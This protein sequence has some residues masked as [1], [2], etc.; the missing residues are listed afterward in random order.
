[1]VDVNLKVPALEKLLDYAASGIGAVAR[2]MLAPWKARR[3]AEAR[4][5]GV[6]AEVESLKLIAK[7]HADA[8]SF[9]VV[10]GEAERGV[11]DLGPDGVAQRIEF[12]EER[13]QANIVSVVQ[14]AATELGDKEVP[15]HEPDHDWIARFLDG[16]QDVSAE[17]MRKIWA[18]FLAG[19]VEAP[20]RTSLRTLSVLKNM[21]Q[22][23]ARTLSEIMRYLIDGFIQSQYCKQSS[24]DPRG[25]FL[26][27]LEKLGIFFNNGT[28]YL[29]QLG[30][31]GTRT[32]ECCNR[33]VVA[34]GSHCHKFRI[35]GII[36]R[37]RVGRQLVVLY[38]IDS[39]FEYLSHFVRLLSLNGCV[40]KFSPVVDRLSGGR[41]GANHGGLRL[42]EPAP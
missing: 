1:M 12:Q 22:S 26:V 3:E 42:F 39:N 23:D 2:S 18:K 8:R 16:F 28:R 21:S 30:E 25:M 20:G 7:T 29:M 36:I 33:A 6:I 17:D 40:M 24:D 41:I 38:G 5:I 37:N 19:D 27:E 34:F 35:H 14:E 15:D 10:P 32:L 31:T 11:L 9:L 4:L 13:R